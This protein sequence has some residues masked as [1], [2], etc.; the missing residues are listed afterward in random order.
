MLPHERSQNS[1]LSTEKI[2]RLLT[3]ILIFKFISSLNSINVY[4]DDYLQYRTLVISAVQVQLVPL[5]DTVG[6]VF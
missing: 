2:I 6:C 5:L 1:L 4:E 3:R